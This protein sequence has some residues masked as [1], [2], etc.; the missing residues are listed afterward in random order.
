MQRPEVVPHVHQLYTTVQGSI[1]VYL[2]NSCALKMAESLPQWTVLIGVGSSG[3]SDD[4]DWQCAGKGKVI[5]L[6]STLSH[7]ALFHA[8]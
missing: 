3:S 4:P 5:V 7:S 1:C 2:R 6:S 8:R